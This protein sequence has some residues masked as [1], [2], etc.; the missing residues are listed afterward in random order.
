MIGYLDPTSDDYL[1]S[2]SHTVGCV[3][4]INPIT[5]SI[6][7]ITRFGDRMIFEMHHVAN[8]AVC[9]G[10]PVVIHQHVTGDTF[11]ETL[12]TWHESWGVIHEGKSWVDATMTEEIKEAA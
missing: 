6:G 3:A 8:N 7:I 11:I 2:E 12:S 9:I 10:M 4:Y 5:R 1:V